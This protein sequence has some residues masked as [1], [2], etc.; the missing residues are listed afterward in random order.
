MTIAEPSAYRRILTSGRYSA[1]PRPE[2]P[3]PVRG[4][5]RCACGQLYALPN[6]AGR[7]PEQCSFCAFAA[8]QAPD[9]P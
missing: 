4:Y 3:R 9:S 6:D 2:R 7:P 5:R 1:A 8:L